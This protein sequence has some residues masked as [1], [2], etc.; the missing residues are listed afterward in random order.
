MVH[1]SLFKT[2]SRGADAISRG[3]KFNEGQLDNSTCV[4][5][6]K[7][8]CASKKVYLTFLQDPVRRARTVNNREQGETLSEKCS[9]GAFVAC[10]SSPPESPVQWERGLRV[11]FSQRFKT[12]LHLK[13]KINEQKINDETTTKWKLQ[14]L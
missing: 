12:V 8:L 6:L 9:L 7:L 3:R 4:S 10:I 2:A 11:H 1:S 13:C 5:S 14:K